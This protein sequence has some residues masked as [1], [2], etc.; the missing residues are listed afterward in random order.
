MLRG[1]LV[2]LKRHHRV[3]EGVATGFFGDTYLQRVCL[4]FFFCPFLRHLIEHLPWLIALG[5]RPKFPLDA[6]SFGLPPPPI[7]CNDGMW[8][9]IPWRLR[10]QIGYGYLPF[11]EGLF[12]AMNGWSGWAL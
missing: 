1:A 7:N 8:Y 3:A 6:F 4:F 11:V 5:G 12:A 2:A 10:H 9:F